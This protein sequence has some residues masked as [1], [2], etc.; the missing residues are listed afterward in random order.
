MPLDGRD[1]K[2]TFSRDTEMITN[3]CYVLAISW[4]VLLFAIGLLPLV[5]GAGVSLVTR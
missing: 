3:A 2:L 5:A 4:P 1:E